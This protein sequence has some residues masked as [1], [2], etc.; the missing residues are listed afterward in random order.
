MKERISAWEE[1][2]RWYRAQPGNE[3]DIRANYFDADVMTAAQRFAV[4]E[5]KRLPR[6][7]GKRPAA[8]Q[9]LS[10]PSGMRP[11]SSS[12][13]VF[14]AQPDGTSEAE[15]WSRPCKDASSK[16]CAELSESIARRTRSWGPCS[17]AKCG[18]AWASSRT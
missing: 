15:A 5:G 7:S 14:A 13:P 8:G 12:L 16:A 9:I 1:A 11:P 10:P 6:L 2:V 4:S 17:S 18:E 3:T